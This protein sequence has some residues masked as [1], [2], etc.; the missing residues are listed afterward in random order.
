MINVKTLFLGVGLG[1]SLSAC[2]VPSHFVIRD[3]DMA[4]KV[5]KIAVFPFQ[6]ANVRASEDPTH[7]KVRKHYTTKFLKHAEKSLS[8]RYEF[9][10]QEEIVKELINSELSKNKS[11]PSREKGMSA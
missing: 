9:I 7:R 2:G 5:K 11:A 4:S 6:N 1:L 8:N 3:A 10:S